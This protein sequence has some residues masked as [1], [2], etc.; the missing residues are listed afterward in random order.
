MDSYLVY[1]T[2]EKSWSSEELEQLFSH[3]DATYSVQLGSKGLD[4][5]ESHD[6]DEYIGEIKGDLGYFR[7]DHGGNLF[8]MMFNDK[9]EPAVGLPNI[10][11]RIQDHM[12]HRLENESEDEAVS[13]FN[14][15]YSFL[16]DFYE[17]LV[18]IS[19]EPVYVYGLNFG[20]CDSV[21]DPDHTRH[22]SRDQ[23]LAG[24]MPGIYWFQIVPPEIVKRMGV[25]QFLSAPAYRVEQLADAAV[26]LAVDQGINDGL[27]EHS[28][29][30]VS[31]YF[32]LEWEP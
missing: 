15:V 22:I 7:I 18:E 25:D 20:E 24:E 11:I 29:K 31:E 21:G 9:M 2:F 14:E 30:D 12:V 4:Q 3:L 17:K 32:G 6:I 16:A 1:Y 10:M 26:F 8:S 28:T 27:F 13:R 5:P 23:L 19:C